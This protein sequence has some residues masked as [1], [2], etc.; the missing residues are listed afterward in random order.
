MLAGRFKMTQHC[1]LSN[2]PHILTD[3]VWNKSCAKALQPQ[4]NSIIRAT[5]AQKCRT[6]HL[7]RQ[8]TSLKRKT[9][10]LKCKT[11]FLKCPTA[12]L[13]RKTAALKRK[14]ASRS[15]KSTITHIQ[16]KC[17]TVLL[18]LHQ[19]PPPKPDQMSL[20]VISPRKGACLELRTK[21][22]ALR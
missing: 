12:S 3:W 2:T 17:C 9:V 19:P 1:R 6:A 14:T 22:P 15:R 4:I 8:A 11:D 16:I 18:Q 5:G 20:S 10:S 7:K 13:K 21:R